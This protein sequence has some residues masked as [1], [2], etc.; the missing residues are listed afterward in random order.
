V[1]RD[2][3]CVRHRSFI[4]GDANRLTRAGPDFKLFRLDRRPLDEQTGDALSSYAL[5]TARAVGTGH[6]GGY[7]RRNRRP[8]QG[9]GQKLTLELLELF[10]FRER[11]EPLVE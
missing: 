5:D 2:E 9:N 1:D 10:P 4:V 8:F 11:L 3:D 7:E 6:H